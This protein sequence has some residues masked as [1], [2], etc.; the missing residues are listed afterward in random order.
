[1]PAARTHVA[2]S[3]NIPIS[4]SMFASY[5]LRSPIRKESNTRAALMVKTTRK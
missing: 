4:A 5:C 3:W 1:M 2:K